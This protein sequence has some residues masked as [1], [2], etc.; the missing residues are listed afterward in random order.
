MAERNEVG[1]YTRGIGHAAG[2][3]T[4]KIVAYGDSPDLRH[5]NN[6]AI[7]QKIDK[8]RVRDARLKAL[9]KR[10]SSGKNAR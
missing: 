5:P 10:A 7:N 2:R 3:P 6:L 9:S 8:D 4:G 1:G